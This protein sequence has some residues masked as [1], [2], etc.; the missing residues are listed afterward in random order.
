MELLKD[1]RKA[2][3]AIEE[4][5]TKLAAAKAKRDKNQQKIAEL[6]EA[7]D[8]AEDARQLA[9]NRFAE[10]KIT[11]K[12]LDAAFIN[13]ENAA[14]AL[15]EVTA[16][17]PVLES[18]I[19]DLAQSIE[20]LHRTRQDIED[21]LWFANGKKIQSEKLNKHIE[22]VHHCVISLLYSKRFGAAL[23]HDLLNEIFLPEPDFNQ[24]I[25]YFE[26]M[27]KEWLSEKEDKK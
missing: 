11:Q 19:W 12:D 6:T 22:D 4:T 13:F 25:S 27:K 10:D 24:R 15:D 1:Y 14:R 16:L 21:Q 5:E 17:H 3:A 23:Y 7:R 26:S 8:K 9:L 20:P 2:N 18:K